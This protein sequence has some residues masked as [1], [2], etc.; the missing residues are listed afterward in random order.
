MMKEVSECYIFFCKIS[1]YATLYLFHYFSIPYAK[2][3]DL[4]IEKSYRQWWP[5]TTTEICGFYVP[6]FPE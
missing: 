3:L 6:H 1:Q 2:L 5:K 4:Y